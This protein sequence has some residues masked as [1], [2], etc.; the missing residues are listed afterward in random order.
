MIFGTAAWGGIAS[1]E[2]V[3]NNQ[4]KAEKESKI[5]TRITNIK[6]MAKLTIST[7]GLKRER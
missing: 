7:T 1:M 6:E 4:E 5:S 2:I 3:V